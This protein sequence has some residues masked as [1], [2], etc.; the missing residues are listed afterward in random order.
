MN[1]LTLRIAMLAKASVREL[2]REYAE[3]YGEDTTSRNRAYLYKR[4]AY[5]LQERELGGLSERAKRR[6]RELADTSCLRAR[7]D[8]SEVAPPLPSA[9]RDKRLPPPGTVLRRTY[10]GREIAVTIAEDGFLFE[11]TVY[12]SLSAIAKVVTGTV[13][14]GLRFFKLE[15]A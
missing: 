12:A 7:P 2:Q 14:N 8:L 6:A 1:A 5:R 10:R 3:V 4:V 11:G 9:P 15:A 13:W